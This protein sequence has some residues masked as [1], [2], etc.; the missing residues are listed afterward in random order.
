M[1]GY[2]DEEVDLFLDE[3][4]DEF[5]R[6][7]RENIEAQETIERL[8]EKVS[9]FDQL[10]E[11]LQHTLVTAQQQADDVRRTPAR[12]PS[13]CCA[14]PSSRAGTS[15]RTRTAK[16]QRV[17]QNLIQL[18]PRSRRTFPL[19]VPVTPG[20]PPQPADGGRVLP[21]PALVPRSGVDRGRGDRP[22]PDDQR[23]RRVPRA[24][25]ACRAVSSDGVDADLE[26]VLDSAEIEPSGDDGDQL[27]TSADED[28]SAWQPN[29]HI[30]TPNRPG[31]RPRGCAQTAAVTSRPSS[32][33]R[34]QSPSFGDR[35]EEERAGERLPSGSDGSGQ[36]RV[37]PGSPHRRPVY[38]RA[39]GEGIREA[40]RRFVFG[41]RD[42]DDDEGIR[43]EASDGKA[44]RDFTW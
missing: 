34:R 10:K 28:A 13:S 42:D 4:A 22:S 24:C 20:S 38:E 35:E 43:T 19:Q 15:W 12:K 41:S 17:Q 36:G 14:T 25:R 26:P 3:V 33:I 11:T 40:G 16:K 27:G 6:L 30:P 29:V 23:A 7:F 44:G 21:G 5:E 1:R 18:P 8:Q 9:E 2:A 31:R 32:G 37:R 39:D